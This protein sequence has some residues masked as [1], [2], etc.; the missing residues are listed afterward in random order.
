MT[1]NLGIAEPETLDPAKSTGVAESTIELNL[2]EGLTRLD[3]DG[4]PTPGIAENWDISEDGKTYTFYLRDAEWNNGDPITA[5][6]F[7]L[8][9]KRALAP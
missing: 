3:K 4:N 7:E 8:S 6:D 1:L 9:W 5:H 2:H